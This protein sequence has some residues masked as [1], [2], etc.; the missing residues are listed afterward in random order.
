[1]AVGRRL[2]DRLDPLA[3][4]LQMFEACDD[5]RVFSQPVAAILQDYSEHA[6][7]YLAEQS[8]RNCA[9]TDAATL[10]GKSEFVS[11]GYRP[12]P[13]PA[14]WDCHQN[15]VGYLGDV[16][17]ACRPAKRFLRAWWKGVAARHGIRLLEECY[18]SPPS[19]AEVP[20]GKTYYV[21]NEPPPTVLDS[22]P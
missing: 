9:H 22:C 18:V 6:A 20:E 1:M 14:P 21:L 17:D 19:P 12:V 16:R 2:W 11:W 15:Q 8:P 5:P 10:I 7:Q 4:Q 13:H 3:L